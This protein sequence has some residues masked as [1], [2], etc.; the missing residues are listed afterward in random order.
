VEDLY[1]DTAI[2]S[3]MIRNKKLIRFFYYLEKF[4][5]KKCTRLSV[6]SEGFKQ[7]ILDKGIPNNKI[8][9]QPIWADPDFI[10]PGT[11]S[12]SFRNLFGLNGQFV[13]LYAGN[14]G[15]TSSLEDII[16][17]AEKLKEDTH[18]RFVLVGEGIKKAEIE[19]QILKR[20]LT[21]VTLLP[22]QPREMLPEMMMAADVGLV[23]M[24]E[25]TSA[26]S[27]PSKVFNVM[28]SAR[29]I[30]SI[31]PANS[32]LDQLVSTNNI[33]IN[34]SPGDCENLQKA[35]LYLL[36]NPGMCDELGKNGRNTLVAEY[37]RS[38]CTRRYEEMI[39]KV[40]QA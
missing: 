14:I 29:P 34:I 27:L 7:I 4:L 33:G 28:A 39:S 13:V 12:N 16:N 3:G 17:V 8:Y 24:N 18:I 21:N 31:A 23:T 15:L 36:E 19:G 30:L 20:S 38:D 26:Y 1:P 40:C 37:S 2:A 25:L 11:K 10:Q 22:F 6:I 35:I 9:V 5:Y 32:E